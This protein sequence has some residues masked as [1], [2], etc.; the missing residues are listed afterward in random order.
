MRNKII[1]FSFKL[2]KMMTK[3]VIKLFFVLISLIAV[4]LEVVCSED[5]LL[6]DIIEDLEDNGKYYY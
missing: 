2:Q 4:N 5:E 3:M 6:R 1:F